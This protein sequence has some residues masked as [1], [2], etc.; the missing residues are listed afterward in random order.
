M[1]ETELLAGSS[2][3]RSVWVLL[4]VVL[5]VAMIGTVATAVVIKVCVDGTGWSE[6]GPGGSDGECAGG[7]AG[8]CQGRWD[9]VGIGRW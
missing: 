1:D 9:R 3:D 6:E 5:A 2:A 4:G 7:W 8:V